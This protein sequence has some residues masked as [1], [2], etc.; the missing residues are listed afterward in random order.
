M[1][2]SAHF[3]FADEGEGMS[4]FGDAKGELVFVLG[5]ESLLCSLEEG[6]DGVFPMMRMSRELSQVHALLELQKQIVAQIGGITALGELRT[7]Q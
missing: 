3:V 1:L 5:F 2:T 4:T 6:A 7:W